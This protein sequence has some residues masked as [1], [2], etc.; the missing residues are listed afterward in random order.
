MKKSEI[1][2]LVVDDHPIVRRGL[3]MEINLHPEMQ[4]VGEARDG[5]EAVAMER[6]LHP[7]V[8]LMDLIMPLKNGV[9]ATAE[10]IAGNP[11]A[12]ILIL[13]SFSE[14]DKIVAAIKAGAMGSIMKDRRPRGVVAGN[15][16]YLRG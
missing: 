2:V 9:E 16:G 8:I 11:T 14:E 12:K 6:E 4:V 1:R 15:Q 3:C 5:I 13:T 7:D 10:I